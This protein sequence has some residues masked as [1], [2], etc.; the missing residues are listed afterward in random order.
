MEKATSG[1]VYNN[2]L[3]HKVGL[4]ISVKN[5]C[6]LKLW[7]NEGKITFPCQPVVTWSLYMATVLPLDTTGWRNVCA[8][9]YHIRAPSFLPLG[10]REYWGLENLHW[11]GLGWLISGAHF[12]KLTQIVALLK[13]WPICCCKREKS[14]SDLELGCIS[15]LWIKWSHVHLLLG[16]C[17]WF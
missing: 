1:H 14:Q 9:G 17:V 6:N 3:K 16:F 12:C 8:H 10:E 5:P 13:I 7:H 11:K 15:R 2:M 4:I